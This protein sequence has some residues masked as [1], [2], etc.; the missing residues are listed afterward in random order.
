MSGGPTKKSFWKAEKNPICVQY[1]PIPV[2][3]DA[4]ARG[5]A[6][7]LDYKD[8][9]HNLGVEEQRSWTKIWQNKEN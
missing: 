1:N 5:L 3:L 2:N 8:K 6:I 4:M 9:D 7:I